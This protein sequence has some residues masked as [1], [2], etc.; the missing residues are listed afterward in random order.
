MSN[1]TVPID[2]SVAAGWLAA[3]DRSH[4]V[5]ELDPDGSIVRAN[6]RL[7]AA[8]GYSESELVGRRHREL[9]VP[10]TRANASAGEPHR[11][12]VYRARNA[13]EVIVRASVTRIP[14]ERERSARF[15]IIGFDVSDQRDLRAALDFRRA[16]DRRPA[17]AAGERRDPLE[18]V[19]DETLAAG[20]LGAAAIADRIDECIDLMRPMAEAKGVALRCT[21]DPDL[22]AMIECDPLRLRQVLLH[23]IGNAVHFTDAG[24]I[25]VCAEPAW[26]D[27]RTLAISVTDTGAGMET[28]EMVSALGSSDG[29]ELAGSS[30]G[31]AVSA[32]TARQMGGV[33][34]LSSERGRGTRAELRLPLRPFGAGLDPFMAGFGYLG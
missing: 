22:P 33:L 5:L 10:G 29:E 23:L 11:T 15:L 7:C 24:W 17:R 14:G 25:S 8:L 9:M 27:P 18:Y 4:F 20:S 26:D 21:F 30:V 3:I 28:A 31:L 16:A 19:F 34:T 6:V 13:R 32:E 2:P 12:I 1:A